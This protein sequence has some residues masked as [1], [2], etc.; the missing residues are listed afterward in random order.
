MFCW[1]EAAGTGIWG[2][3][4]PIFG[5]SAGAGEWREPRNLGGRTIPLLP[6][7]R[8]CT[9]KEVVPEEAVSIVLGLYPQTQIAE[10]VAR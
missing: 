6:Q 7:L 9:F 10:R 5:L 8:I 3:L 1:G 4:S 2:R